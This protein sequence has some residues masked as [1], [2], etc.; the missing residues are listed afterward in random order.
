MQ[1]DLVDIILDYSTFNGQDR[2]TVRE[3]SNSV[4]C[5][6]SFPTWNFCL[7]SWDKSI[8]I[9]NREGQCLQ[10][11]NGKKFVLS[12]LYC[13]IMYMCLKSFCF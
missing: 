9:W 4:H 13:A 1:P 8:K 5:V 2:L 7:G 11:L 3:H 6:A 12:I 10:T